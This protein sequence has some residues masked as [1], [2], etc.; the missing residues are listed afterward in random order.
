MIVLSASMLEH[1]CV[2]ADEMTQ[3]LRAF[4]SKFDDLSFTPSS[5]ILQIVLFP[6][7]VSHNTGT[8]PPI[9]KQT[10]IQMIS[11]VMHELP[12]TPHK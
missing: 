10:N 4:A 1:A 5:T 7:H 3:W 11:R 12:H 8:M 6:P 9:N 2:E